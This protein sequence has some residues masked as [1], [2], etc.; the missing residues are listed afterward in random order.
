MKLKQENNTSS[1]KILRT[2]IAHN[3]KVIRKVKGL[4]LAEV[5]QVIGCSGQQVQKYETGKN[6]ISISAL[7][8][9]AD[10][11]NIPVTFFFKEIT[12]D[13]LSA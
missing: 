1:D 6:K 11:L 9:F 3:F 4:N 8:K 2:V 10:F 7:V 12:L 5:G 13:A